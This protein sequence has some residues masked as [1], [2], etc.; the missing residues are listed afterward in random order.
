M[1]SATQRQ[2]AR[3]S[4]LSPSRPAGVMGAFISLVPAP[5]DA[6][7][8]GW[9]GLSAGLLRS[10]IV[11]GVSLAT[12]QG[13]IERLCNGSGQEDAGVSMAKRCVGPRDSHS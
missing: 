8:E 2:L 1:H 4:S 12:G 13:E 5:L 9:W 10:L 6:V 7:V 3:Y 11:A